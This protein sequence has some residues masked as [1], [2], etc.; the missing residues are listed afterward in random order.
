M[1]YSL[2]LMSH[3]VQMVRKLKQMDTKE[4][5]VLSTEE[6]CLDQTIIV[7][8]CLQQGGGEDCERY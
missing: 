4:G 2:S 6:I 8:T 7:S 5:F 1:T 3:C